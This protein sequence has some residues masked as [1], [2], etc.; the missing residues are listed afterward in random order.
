MPRFLRILAAAPAVSALL[1]ATAGPARAHVEPE[2][3]EVPAGSVATV[4]FTVEHG[5]DGAPTTT[6][7]LQVPPEAADASPVDK[8]GWTTTVDG[9]V[10]AFAGGPLPD[11]VQAVFELRFTAPTTVGTVMTF[12]MVQTCEDGGTLGWIQLDD[13]ARYPA[14]T[15]EVGGPDPDGPLPTTAPDPAEPDESEATPTTEVPSTTT[16]GTDADDDDLAVAP[17]AATGDVSGGSAAPWIIGAVVLAVLAAGAVAGQ[18]WRSG[19]TTP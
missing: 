11:D 14:P 7:E 19:R 15:V 5:C 18:R 9:D 1:V 13:G 12:P 3:T 4:G 8:D 17:S 2:V 6:L 16:A 10:I